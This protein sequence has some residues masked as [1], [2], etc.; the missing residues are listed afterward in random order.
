M[1][2]TEMEILLCETEK[3]PETDVMREIEA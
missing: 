3:N 1:R 2:E